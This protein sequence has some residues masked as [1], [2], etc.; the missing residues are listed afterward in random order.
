MSQL[1]SQL[2][3]DWRLL[4]SQA[5]N[6]FLVLIVLRIF[7]YKPLLKLLHDR[8]ERIEGG[9]MKAEEADRRLLEVEEIGKG[10]IK[11]AENSALNILKKTEIDAKDLESKMLAEAKR[12]EAAELANIQVLLRAKE[13]ESRRAAEKEAAMLVRR[14]IVRTVELAPEKIDDALIAKAVGDATNSR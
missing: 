8:R 9:I 13:E 14:A 1:I 12:K 3:I 11:A 10:K 6:F 4:L 5:V 2:G 7:V